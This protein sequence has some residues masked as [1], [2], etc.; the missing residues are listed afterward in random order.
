[1]N[2][3]ATLEGLRE[4]QMMRASLANYAIKKKYKE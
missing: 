2:K 4:K 1:M 3:T